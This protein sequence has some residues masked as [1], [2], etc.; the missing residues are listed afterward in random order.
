M[1]VPHSLE[2]EMMVL[3]AMLAKEAWKSRGLE[4]LD[5]DDFFT[6]QC[7][8]A[9]D[10]V[11]DLGEDANTLT[12]TTRFVDTEKYKTF[13]TT[14]AAEIAGIIPVGVHFESSLKILREKSGL[15]CAMRIGKGIVDAATNSS[16]SNHLRE[17]VS[18]GLSE[19]SRRTISSTRDDSVETIASDFLE[20]WEAAN[21]GEK[22]PGIKVPWK[23]FNNK[24]GGLLPSYYVV[25]GVTGGGKTTFA[26]NLVDSVLEAEKSVLIYS[27]EMPARDIL[28]RLIC[29][30][31]GIDSMK[32][33]NPFYHRCSASEAL[34]IRSSAR[35]YARY[36]NRLKIVAD[37]LMSVEQ[38]RL[39]ARKFTHEEDVGLVIVDY[40]QLVPVDSIGGDS[41]REQV[42]A[43][44][45]NT[46]RAV[47]LEMKVPVVA[48]SQLNEDGRTRESRSLEQDAMIILKVQ[49][50]EL[51]VQK[52]RNLPS[53]YTLPI[54]LHK[55]VF[56][57][58]EN[59]EEPTEAVTATTVT[60]TKKDPF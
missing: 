9:F 25:S 37:P 45:S 54:S 5:R 18:E 27:Y 52:N 11:K 19:I 23:S 56:K 7:Q 10:A 26:L 36:G 50:D 51:Y 1:V 33:F 16:D 42:V 14:F 47:A 35:Q 4:Q 40:A 28:G 43:R 15:R 21:A 44:I 24:L 31:S 30:H 39:E 46:L 38:I 3:A 22:Q 8:W 57:F 6:P 34:D 20:S 48:L 55:E 60:P 53:N 29:M 41:I 2:A 49:G 13:G 32:I 17:I 58:L 12:L 59:E